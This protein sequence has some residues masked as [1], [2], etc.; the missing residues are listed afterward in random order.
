[1]NIRYPRSILISIGAVLLIPAYLTALIFGQAAVDS[2]TY[3]DTEGLLFVYF[4]MSYPLVFLFSLVASILDYKEQAGR[5][6]LSALPLVYAAIIVVW[7]LTIV[8]T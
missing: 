2:P 4:T 7:I 8:L 5:I 1:M 3:P 6:Y